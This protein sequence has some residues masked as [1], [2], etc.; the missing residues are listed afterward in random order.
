MGEPIVS[1]ALAD[2][3]A[4]AALAARV[5]DALPEDRGG[6][7]LGLRGE[8]GA[9][10]STFARAMLRSLG[11]R[12]TVPSPTYTLI[13]PYDL[14]TGTVYHIDL[15]RI[16][17]SNELEF[18]G[19]TDLCDGLRLIEWPERAPQL[20]Q[21]ADL[22]VAIRYEGA[23]RHADIRAQTARGAAVIERLR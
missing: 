2:E 21:A 16:V 10:K 7:L 1:I 6:W 17:D 11:H 19:L 13:E 5:A 8:L 20:Q 18:L 23:G 15:Y 4:T 3:D 14:E 22:D 9:G 12:G